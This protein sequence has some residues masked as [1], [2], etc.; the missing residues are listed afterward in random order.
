[1]EMNTR[2]NP[3]RPFAFVSILV[4]LTFLPIILSRPATQSKVPTPKPIKP[5]DAEAKK[6]NISHDQGKA[7]YLKLK[8]KVCE[9]L[10][11]CWIASGYNAYGDKIL[12]K[13]FPTTWGSKR[14]L[15]IPRSEWN[16]LNDDDR[17]QL[18]AYLEGIGVVN[19]TVGRILPARYADDSINPD[20]NTITADETVWGI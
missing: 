2:A 19:I 4:L 14:S 18:G 12:K 20:R 15:I 6:S 7:I 3:W 17:E 16:S 8:N 5:I 11:L 10:D 1:M 9:K 13:E